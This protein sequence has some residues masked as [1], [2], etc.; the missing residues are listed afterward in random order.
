MKMKNSI[1]KA[2]IISM[3]MCLTLAP[4]LSADDSAIIIE[5]EKLF[6]EGKYKQS[7]ALL[8]LLYERDPDNVDV[9][10]MTAR[11]YY[12][13]GEIIPLE[14]NKR[15]KLMMYRISQSWALKGYNKNPE[16]AENAF[17]VGVAMSMQVL[18]QGIAA[19][20]VRDRTKAKKIELYFKQTL[21]AKE[22]RVNDEFMNTN[23]AANFALGIFYR[24]VPESDLIVILIGTKGDMDKSVMHLKKALSSFP[25]QMEF[26]KE[27]GVSYFCRGKRRKNPQDMEEGKKYLN[28]VLELPVEKELDK[29]DHEDARKLLDDPSL[30][31]GYSR[32]RQE[33]VDDDSI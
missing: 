5:C 10:W 26:N 29:I 12:Q 30:A 33:E 6:N 18:V 32:V 31:C 20:M 17:F 19:S 22:I 24:K 14:K 3:V 15:E 2:L 27:L 21:E 23:A 13:M 7:N 25:N 8:K 11:N 4:F 28:R 16:I 1:S 9:Y